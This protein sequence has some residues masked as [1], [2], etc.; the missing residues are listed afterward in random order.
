MEEVWENSPKKIEENI[1]EVISEKSSDT[2]SNSSY[3]EMSD[4]ER[5]GVILMQY[6]DILDEVNI[7][8]MIKIGLQEDYE[9][10]YVMKIISNLIKKYKHFDIINELINEIFCIISLN[11][12]N[13]LDKFF[14][15][16]RFDFD[17]KHFELIIDDYYDVL[18]KKVLLYI[19][20]KYVNLKWKK[21]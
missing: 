21:P 3:E 14:N 19:L 2:D 17:I 1:T 4:F 20:N 12:L 9:S 6:E 15:I 18:K 5:M 7:Q 11:G 10:K 8:K 13:S 16:E